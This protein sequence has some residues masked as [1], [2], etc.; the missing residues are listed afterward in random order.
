MSTLFWRFDVLAMSYRQ[1]FKPYD[2]KLALAGDIL[3][4]VQALQD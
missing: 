4:S 2:L 3:C 1:A